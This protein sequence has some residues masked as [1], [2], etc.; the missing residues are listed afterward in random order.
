MCL[1]CCYARVMFLKYDVSISLTLEI[2]FVQTSLLSDADDNVCAGIY[3]LRG[4]PDSG[5][6]HGDSSRYPSA[7]DNGFLGNMK[8]FG[9]QPL[10]KDELVAYSAASEPSRLLD[11]RLEGSKKSSGS[12][13]LL[14]EFVSSNE[15]GMTLLCFNGY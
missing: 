4:K 1:I 11:P 2:P 13:T 14:K 6:M 10:P 5:P 8:L 12:V 3:M 7:N 15:L 9:N